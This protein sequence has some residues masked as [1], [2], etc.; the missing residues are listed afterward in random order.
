MKTVYIGVNSEV[1]KVYRA[2]TKNISENKDEY[3]V[4]CENFNTKLYIAKDTEE[5]KKITNVLDNKALSYTIE[6]IAM[7]ISLPHLTVKDILQLLS[8]EYDK[9][10][11][12]GKREAICNVRKALELPLSF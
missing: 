8:D 11:K 4:K 2:I 10:F 3:C 6:K 5:G 7:K 1:N 9:A 12:A